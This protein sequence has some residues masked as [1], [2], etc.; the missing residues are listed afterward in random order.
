[1]CKV[2]EHYEQL[3]REDERRLIAKEMQQK[4]EEL[5]AL[6]AQLEALRKGGILPQNV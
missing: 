6:R 4:D 2:M 1:M 5:A 3:A